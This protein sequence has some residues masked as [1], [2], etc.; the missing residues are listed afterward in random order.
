VKK[1]L[2][3]IGGG[4]AHVEV[5]R[6]L[7]LNPPSEA[8]IAL[9]NPSPSVLYSSMVPGVIAGHYE[10]VEAKI[11]L[12]ALCQR[13][14]VRFFETSVLA[15]NASNLVLESG[16][17]ERHRFDF[18][19]VD[20]GG[21]SQQL[22]TSPGAYVVTVKPVDALLAAIAEF[23]SVRSASLMVRII[24]N[25]AAALEVALA[26]AF[27]WRESNNRRVSIVAATRLMVGYPPRVRS[28]ALRA[29]NKLGVSVLENKAVEHIEPTRLRLTSGEM[30]DTQLTVLATGHAPVALMKKTDLS[31]TADGNIHV[32]T[33]L[34]SSNHPHIFAAGDCADVSGLT[35]PK[36][37]VFSA[38]QGASLA[39][40]LLAKFNNA[41]LVPY[42]HTPGTLNLL[43][44]GDK[45]AIATRSGLSTAG[46]W[47]WRWKDSNDRKWIDRYT[48]D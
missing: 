1:T 34:Q 25:S 45:R 36:S 5:L 7:A 35:I 26:L 18:A 20:V 15:L 33:S 31:H 24:G 12:W 30:I 27:R 47:A 41:P 14:R 22:P 3:L 37:S 48:L 42:R 21:V 44:L 13:A 43:S 2:L 16:I 17:G 11:N 28:L 6:Q 46:R 39:A 40:N 29:C 9:F 4:Q 23:E 19:S 38:R 10:A 8:D 32:N